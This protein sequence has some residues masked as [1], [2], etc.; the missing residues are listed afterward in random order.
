M[1]KS[2]RAKLSALAACTV[3]L[4]TV[5]VMSGCAAD[6]KPVASAALLHPTDA[7]YFSLAKT[8]V[9]PGQIPGDSRVGVPV[10][11]YTPKDLDVLQLQAIRR[12]SPVGWWVPVIAATKTVCYYDIR[13]HEAMSTFGLVAVHFDDFFD[14]YTIAQTSLRNALGGRPETFT[15]VDENWQLLLGLDGSRPALT[16]IGDAH[17]RVYEGQAAVNILRQLASGVLPGS[18]SPA[19]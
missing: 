9:S 1:R 7:R 15:L 16:V 5:A 14:Q 6:H 12:K 11:L 17:R 18:V 8:M 10:P 3:L 19:L 13:T 4:L 2:V